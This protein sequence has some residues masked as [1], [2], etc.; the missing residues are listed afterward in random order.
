MSTKRRND[1]AAKEDCIG[2]AVSAASP[3]ERK[4][5]LLLKPHA[6]N[7]HGGNAGKSPQILDVDTQWT[8]AASFKFW[9]L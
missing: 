7:A 1:L 8:T 3:D 4:P 6:I 2:R 5:A 9:P